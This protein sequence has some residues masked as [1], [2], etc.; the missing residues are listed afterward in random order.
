MEFPKNMD[1]ESNG[2]D[3]KHGL[4]MTSQDTTS[5]MSIS[6]EGSSEKI[7]LIEGNLIPQQG[8]SE[9]NKEAMSKSADERIAQLEDRTSQ[10]EERISQLEERIAQ[11]EERTAQLEKRN[12]ELEKRNAEL[13]EELRKERQISFDLRLQLQEAKRQV[14]FKNLV[15]QYF[16]FFVGTRSNT[17][18]SCL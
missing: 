17:S 15:F 16:P 13:E 7:S 10:L 9:G 4:S 2:N 1:H 14:S 11:L 3:V 6:Q 5:M 18:H 8:K 12:A